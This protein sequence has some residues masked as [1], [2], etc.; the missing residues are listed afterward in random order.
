M[1]PD[2]MTFPS[3]EFYDGKL[4]SGIRREDRL[5]SEGLRWPSRVPVAVLEVKGSTK[6]RNSS[7]YNVEE[8]NVIKKIISQVKG[9]VAIITPYASLS[10]VCLGSY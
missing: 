3:A 4:Q 8:V 7:L 5:Q 2:L 10:L 6:R 9:K 1:H